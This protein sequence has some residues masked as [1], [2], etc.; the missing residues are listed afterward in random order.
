MCLI[1]SDDNTVEIPNLAPINDARVLFPVPD[2][3]PS[4]IIKFNLLSKLKLHESFCYLT[5]YKH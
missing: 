4:K 1:E 5:I 3:P 2:A